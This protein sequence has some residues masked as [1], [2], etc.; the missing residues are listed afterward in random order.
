MSDLTSVEILEQ[1]VELARNRYR[2]FTERLKDPKNMDHR[3]FLLHAVS[4]TRF[5][6]LEAR[7]DFLAATARAVIKTANKADIAALADLGV[8]VENGEEYGY[9]GAEADTI[10]LWKDAMAALVVALAAV[11]KEKGRGE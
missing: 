1:R 2:E 5:E 10:Q 11:D 9:V 6:L 4:E 7:M 3:E 8:M